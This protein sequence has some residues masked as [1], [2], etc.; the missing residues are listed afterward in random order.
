LTVAGLNT[1]VRVEE[2]SRE[3]A[4]YK[5]SY[6]AQDDRHHDAFTGPREEGGDESGNRAEDDPR[7]DAHV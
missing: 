7:D 4:A 2:G 1:P 3:E 5:G 6:D